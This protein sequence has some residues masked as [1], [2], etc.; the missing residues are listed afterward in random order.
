VLLGDGCRG[1]GPPTQ[2]EPA[3]GLGGP[4]DTPVATEGADGRVGGL[5]SAGGGGGGAGAGVRVV[6]VTAGVGGHS[7]HLYVGHPALWWAAGAALG[8]RC[9]RSDEEV[10]GAAQ[11]HQMEEEEEEEEVVAREDDM[12]PEPAPT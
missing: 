4:V 3:L 11:P 8:V 7:P 1:G 2:G 9:T 5:G 10:G 6:D 12:Q